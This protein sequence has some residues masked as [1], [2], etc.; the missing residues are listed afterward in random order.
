MFNLVYSRGYFGCGKKSGRPRVYYS[1]ATSRNQILKH[2]ILK[3]VEN[4]I[5][6][7]QLIKGLR[8]KYNECAEFFGRTKAAIGAGTRSSTRAQNIAS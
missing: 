3:K 1:I 7:T 6:R 8:D 5:L 2:F 4:F